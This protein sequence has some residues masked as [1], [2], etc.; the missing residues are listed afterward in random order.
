MSSQQTD[1][2]EVFYSYALQDDEL[3][4]ELEKH[5]IKAKEA[6]AKYYNKNHTS[7]EYNIGKI[8]LLSAKNISTIQPS[9]KLGHRQLS[10]FEVTKQ[11]GKQAY[12]LKLPP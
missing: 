8:V 1:L 11:I 4:Q 7:I 10:P 12:K 6:Q 2:A 5:Q 9:K 3:Q